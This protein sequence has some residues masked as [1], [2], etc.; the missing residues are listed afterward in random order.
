MNL[1]TE[2]H[3][4]DNKS[5]AVIF[6]HGLGMDKNIWVNPESSRIL[7]GLFPL[8]VLLKSQFSPREKTA[9]MK[10][11]YE[12]LMERG[13]PV[14]TWSQ[15]RPAG[16]IDSAV[17]E[18]DEIVRIAGNLSKSGI[19]LVGHSRGGLIARK[20]LMV[21]HQEIRGLITI[22]TPHKGSSVARFSRYVA[23][24]VSM[25]NPVIPAGERG[26]LIFSVKKILEFLRSKA[27]K[28]LL[29]ESDF[30]RSLQDSPFDHISYA[31]AG[32]TDPTLFRVFNFSFPDA[33]EKVMPQRFFPEEM[34]EGK[35][36][37]LVT[38]E[39]ARMPWASEHDDYACNHA[40]ILFDEE[41]KK[42]LTEKIAEI[43]SI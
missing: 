1:D 40:G 26:T 5:P 4:G 6:I 38:A 12:D 39:S 29:P 37:G 23:P 7:G 10:T 42:K 13:Y 2:I 22:S 21:N 25:I 35:G 16:P 24:L 32:G 30:F 3:Q 11:L 34:K 20:Y 33:F 31:S 43:G 14:V 27:L 19:I 15:K 9:G 41:V 8:S 36:D 28:E 17:L 18:L